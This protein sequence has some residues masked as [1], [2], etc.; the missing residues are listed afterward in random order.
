MSFVLSCLCI[1]SVSTNAME[2][3]NFLSPLHTHT[4][5]SGSCVCV[6]VFYLRDI[7]SLLI[8]PNIVSSY[9]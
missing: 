8:C 2:R 7:L 9:F 6:C 5:K 1:C 3:W 4:H